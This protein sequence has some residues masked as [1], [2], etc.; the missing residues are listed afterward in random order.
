M[1]FD[2]NGKLIQVKD[3]NLAAVNKT[4]NLDISIA[5]TYGSQA[6]GRNSSMSYRTISIK[7]SVPSTGRFDPKKKLIGQFEENLK[8]IYT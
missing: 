7:S 1:T 3:P 8:H 4:I 2:Y 5:G 6:G